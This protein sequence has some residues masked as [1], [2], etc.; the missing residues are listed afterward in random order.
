[1]SVRVLIAERDPALR[2]QI[3][4][5]VASFEGCEVVG[6]AR[7]GQETIQMAVLLIPHV[8]VISQDLPGISGLQACEILSALAPDVMSVLVTSGKA[9]DKLDSAMRAGARAVITKPLDDSQLRTVINELAELRK[10]RESPEVLDWRDPS[11]FPKVVSVTGAKGGVGK[12]TIAVNLAVLLAKRL[13]NR[14]AIV[15]LYTQFGDIAMMLNVTPKHTIAEMESLC[16]EVD[17]DLVQSYVTKHPSGVHV[18]AA[19]VTPV[20]LSAVSAECLDSLLYVL[21][22]TYRYVVLDVPPILHEATLHALAHSN[23]VLLI[24]NL[25]D[26]TTASDTKK[27]YDA[28]QQEH[29]SKENIKIVLN[30]VLKANRLRTADIERMFDC[31]ILAQIPNDRRMVTSVNQGIPLALSDGD[32]PIGRSF[33]MLA[34]AVAGPIGYR[35]HAERPAT[36]KGA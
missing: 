23:M 13:P 29:I 19:S 18:L 3:R 17:T 4:D 11:R 32:S 21:K 24:A 12:T 27:I 33:T 14:V 5:T 15:D 16:D 2:N 30:R 31:D 22:R 6:M 26:L 28:L 7:D 1:M 8:A 20:P 25:F 36:K 10:R 34:D 35:S 9:Q